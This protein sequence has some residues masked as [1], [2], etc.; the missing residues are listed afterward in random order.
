MKIILKHIL[1]NIREKKG[2]TFLIVLALTIASM[3]FTLNLILPDEIMVKL[4]ETYNTIYGSTD[5]VISDE[6]EFDIRNIDLGSEEIHC[7][8]MLLMMTV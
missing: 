2:R 3:V 8:S 5:I 7:L 4:K 1:R 6:E